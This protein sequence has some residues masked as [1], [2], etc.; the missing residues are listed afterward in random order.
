MKIN[1]DK[2]AELDYNSLYKALEYDEITGIFSWKSPG[3]NRIV[4]ERAGYLHHTG[5]RYIELKSRP[6]AEHRLAWLYCFQEWPIGQIDHIDLDRSNNILDNL[7]EVSNRV[8]ATN[9]TNN[10]KYG[11]NISKNKSKF[12][13]RFNIKG[14]TTNFGSHTIEGATLVRDY[15]YNLLINNMPVPTASEIY[16]QLNIPYN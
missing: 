6:Y 2:E 1:I 4:G 15:V 9:K 11:H 13:V 8:N 16:K 10:S 5:Y 3:R 14:K 7:R 12:L